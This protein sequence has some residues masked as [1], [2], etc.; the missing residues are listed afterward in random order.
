M[1]NDTPTTLMLE[2]VSPEEET[3]ELKEG[4]H[5]Q[6]SDETERAV[7][8]ELLCGVVDWWDDLPIASGG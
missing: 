3:L 7:H 4:E 5:A 6:R 1:A 8:G 2:K